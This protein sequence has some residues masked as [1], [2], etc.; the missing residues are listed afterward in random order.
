MKWDKKLG[1]VWDKRLKVE[2]ENQKKSVRPGRKGVALLSLMTLVVVAQVAVERQS[3]KAILHILVS[4][5]GGKR[6]VNCKNPGSTR[7]QPGVNPGSTRGQPEPPHL[8]RR[9][10]RL[11][12]VVSIR[13]LQRLGGGSGGALEAFFGASDGSA[14]EGRWLQ[15]NAK[16]ESS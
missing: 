7:G 3:L 9:H 13:R 11:R 2:M 4:K 1:S 16:F 8:V 14:L 6:G 12:R 15:L 5:P 10:L